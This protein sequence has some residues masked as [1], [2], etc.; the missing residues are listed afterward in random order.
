MAARA[1]R[2]G[3]IEGPYSSKRVHAAATAR[4]AVPGKE[5]GK[6]GERARSGLLEKQAQV[7]VV[8]QELRQVGRAQFRQHHALALQRFE[9]FR[10]DDTR[11]CHF[12]PEASEPVR[13][14]SV[15]S[16]CSL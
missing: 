5:N 16:K 4:G 12:W 10:N 7:R 3:R 2:E 13:V 11:V 9:T 15:H 1:L 8:S 6:A 14:H